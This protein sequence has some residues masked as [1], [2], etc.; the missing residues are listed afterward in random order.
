MAPAAPCPGWSGERTEPPAVSARR[1]RGDAE[2]RRAADRGPAQDELETPLTFKRIFIQELKLNLV[3]ASLS[4]EPAKVSSHPRRLLSSAQLA[5][6]PAS[7]CVP[8]RAPAL[9]GL[10]MPPGNG[11][12]VRRAARA[13]P[14]AQRGGGPAGRRRRVRCWRWRGRRRG[15][16]DRRGRRRADAGQL[17]D[18]LGV[19][20]RHA[21]PRELWSSTSTA[22]P[23]AWRCCA[24]S[25]RRQT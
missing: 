3:W 4:Y 5:R 25:P 7:S 19:L 6:Q 15:R 2:Q 24:A 14:G 20:S 18:E 10:I 13:D 16:R 8:A 17:A 12:R 22:S 1:W 21:G 9:S 11:A 23:S